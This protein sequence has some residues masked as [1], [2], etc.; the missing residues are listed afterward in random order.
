MN[1]TEGVFFL[2]LTFQKVFL[3]ITILETIVTHLKVFKL[4]SKNEFLTFDFHNSVC[5]QKVNA[6]MKIEFI[7][8]KHG[9]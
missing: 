2:K 8:Q 3:K 6:K 1:P 4:H 7:N 5:G 9:K